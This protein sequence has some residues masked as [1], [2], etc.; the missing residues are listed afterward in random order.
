M[1]LR[2]GRAIS[3][4]AHA[5]SLKATGEGDERDADIRCGQRTAPPNALSTPRWRCPRLT[6][7]R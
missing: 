3:L 5:P 4:N 7:I 2:D 1:R 6:L